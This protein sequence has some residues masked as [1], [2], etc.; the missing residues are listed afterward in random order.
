MGVAP[1][2]ATLLYWSTQTV[3]KYNC[4]INFIIV[5][6]RP[7]NSELFNYSFHFSEHQESHAPPDAKPYGITRIYFNE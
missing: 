5:T 6:D 7:R 2:E 4:I 1:E 3:V